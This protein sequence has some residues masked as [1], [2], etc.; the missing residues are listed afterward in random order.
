[1]E[2]E[3]KKDQTS[4]WKIV[5]IAFAILGG[6]ALISYLSN[7][8]ILKKDSKKY[9]SQLEAYLTDLKVPFTIVNTQYP[10]KEY[11]S[12]VKWR[13]IDTCSGDI[14]AQ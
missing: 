5:I 14:V 10:E 7:D 6:F 1:M 2:E 3:E 8:V 11:E 4:L 12:D 9:I 13:V